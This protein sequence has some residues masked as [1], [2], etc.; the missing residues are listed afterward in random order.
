MPLNELD[1]VVVLNDVTMPTG[2]VIKKGTQGMI[3]KILMDDGKTYY[4][5]T[6]NNVSFANPTFTFEAGQVGDIENNIINL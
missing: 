5:V 4:S 2:E 6:L 1:M 3:S